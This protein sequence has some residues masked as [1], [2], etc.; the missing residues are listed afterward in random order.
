MKNFILAL[1]ILG[2]SI[3]FADA[4]PAKHR[5]ARTPWQA[6]STAL[7]KASQSCFAA[8]RQ[9]ARTCGT[10]APSVDDFSQFNDH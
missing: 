3:G 8:H 9:G 10:S 4:H 5:L 7:Q 2:T 1:A 6:N